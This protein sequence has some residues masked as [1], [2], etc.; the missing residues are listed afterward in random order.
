MLKKGWTGEIVSL[1]LRKK[2]LSI[3]IKFNNNPTEGCTL[4]NGLG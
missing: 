1:E 2:V 4:R 3:K